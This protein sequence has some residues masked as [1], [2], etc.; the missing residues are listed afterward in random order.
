M[1]SKKLRPGAMCGPWVTSGAGGAIGGYGW[2][3]KRGG[4]V[5]TCGG[6]TSA[7]ETCAG[8]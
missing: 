1:S 3:G 7:I 2:A 4:R 6:V 8:T 5:E